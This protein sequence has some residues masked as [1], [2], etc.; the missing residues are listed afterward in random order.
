MSISCS[1]KRILILKNRPSLEDQ[2]TP[3]KT[4]SDFRLGQSNWCWEVA[5]EYPAGAACGRSPSS[6][7]TIVGIGLDDPSGKGCSHGIPPPW[8]PGIVSWQP[9]QK[10]VEKPPVVDRISMFFPYR[11]RLLQGKYLWIPMDWWPFARWVD[12]PSL[13]VAYV[14]GF[15]GM[16][17]NHIKCP[18]S[19]VM[20]FCSGY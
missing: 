13:T 11:K 12:K 14:E 8:D 4:S 5:P 2:K 3:K 18:P 15:G 6:P 16:T 19:G 20:F 17:F 7:E 9:R 10:D 1:K